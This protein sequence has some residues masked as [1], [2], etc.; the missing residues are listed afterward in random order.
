MIFKFI[1][2]R[3]FR[4][5]N[6]RF[7]SLPTQFAIAFV[8]IA[9]IP[10]LLLSGLT[11]HLSQQALTAA[12]YQGLVASATQTS[13]SID[14]FISENLDSIRSAAL[15][16][17]MAEFLQLPTQER[18]SSKEEAHMQAN[19]QALLRRSG[20]NIM[21]YSLLDKRGRVV[22][23]SRAALDYQ[24]F[25]QESFFQEAM[26]TGL[27]H[28][29][30][31]QFLKNQRDTPVVYFSSVVRAP[32][33]EAIGVLVACYSASAIQQ[34]V[35]RNG[36][37]AGE[38]SFA[39]LL[40]ENDIRIAHGNNPDLA[41][42]PVLP[43]SAEKQKQLTMRHRLPEDFA[44]LSPA[45]VSDLEPILERDACTSRQFCQPNY[46]TVTLRADITSKEDTSPQ[47]VFAI[48]T[49]NTKNQ[50]WTLL[51]ATPKQLLLAPV[52][53]QMQIALL[54]S[55]LIAIAVIFLAFWLG[56]QLAQPIIDLTQQ[57]IDF[58]SGNL[59]ARVSYQSRDEIGILAKSFN[60]MAEQV[61]SLL[62][63]RT[64]QL[65]AVQETEAQY[66]HKA[67][68]L[69]HTLEE[70]QRT[71]AQLLQTEKMS[72]LGQ[73][74]AGVAHEINNPASFIHGNLTHL[75][76]YADALFL[77][78]DLYQSTYPQS[79]ESLQKAEKSLDVPFIRKD[80]PKLIHSMTNG[81]DRI[82]NIVLSLRNFARL[83]ESD[84]KK[85]DLYEGLDNTLMI[86]SN[87]LNATSVRRGGQE[88]YRPEI[89]IIKHY[90]LLPE[91][92]CYPSDLN[93]VFLNLL[94]NAIDAIEEHLGREE[95]ADF[96]PTIILAGHILN[97]SKQIELTF[98]NTGTPID[99]KIQESIFDP[100]FTTKAVGKGTGMGLA[101][102]Y[103][104]I[105]EKHGGQITC[106]SLPG[107]G[108]QFTVTL[109]INQ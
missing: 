39:I 90:D 31:V 7:R 107:Q 32:E 65:Q 53:A 55:S 92:T 69:A 4:A 103:K 80:F 40:D 67:E 29:S 101:I 14:T 73:M 64:Q 1:M 66:R 85:A 72:S 99:P 62:Q 59:Q 17:D 37:L 43:L 58:T 38:G 9:L 60:T 50:P 36:G 86:L 33:G 88:F 20:L 42:R 87:R 28:I 75:Q 51:Y 61:G 54:L 95:L 97:D 83:D 13:Q 98:I 63:E 94:N 74:V 49:A 3:F 47:R 96:T 102:C 24:I 109:P 44:S 104:I 15:Q 41:F 21:F 23:N 70:L 19:F 18:L 89:Q 34:L 77:F 82:R 71:Q 52:R 108:T 45:Y 91:I 2:Q 22:I 57:V 79:S 35:Q 48:A 106:K 5:D 30:P 6:L 56:K 76:D 78:I 11:Q 46:S 16:P 8:A 68:E 27:P 12:A 105:T 100:F 10:L 84:L 26:S 25:S 93:Q 81:T